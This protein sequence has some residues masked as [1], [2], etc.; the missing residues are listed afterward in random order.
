MDSPQ[1]TISTI[2]FIVSLIVP[3]IIFKRFYYQG[4]FTKQFGTDPFADRLITSLFWGIFVQI[5]AFLI[6]SRYFGFTYTSIKKQIDV[7]YAS[8]VQNKIPDITYKQIFYLL[9]YLIFS[10]ITAL[11]LGSLCHFL[12][13]FLKLDIK[14]NVLRF[15][16]RWNYLIRGDILATREFKSAKKG[17]V[18]FTVVDI[19]IDDATEK[20]KMISGVLTDYIISEK[21]G[22]LETVYLTAAKKY[23]ITNNTPKEIPGD[24]LIVPCHRMV[25][26]NLTYILK[27]VDK[28]KKRQIVINLYRFVTSIGMLFCL[29]YPWYENINLINKI[30]SILFSSFSLTLLMTL[31]HSSV[32]QPDSNTKLEKGGIIALVVC[33]I[34]FLFLTLLFLHKIP[35]IN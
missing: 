28:N 2:F 12:I 14:F 15:S 9:G 33:F 20:N 31:V 21:T 1:F 5:I 29:I 13:R 27:V 22:E 11:L 8:I 7:V 32:L 3:G 30:L 17:K 25:N 35:G 24:C 6:F 19:V 18:L 10:V 34:I 4:Q 16:N 23:S 26:M